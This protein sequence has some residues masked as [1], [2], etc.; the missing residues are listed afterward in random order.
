MQKNEKKTRK[1]ITFELAIDKLEAITEKLSDGNLS[2]DEALKLYEEGMNIKKIC[3]ERLN[4]AE[5]KIKILVKEDRGLV[6][7]DFELKND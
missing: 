2:L 6:E 7:Q 5:K 4:A 3:I 1:K